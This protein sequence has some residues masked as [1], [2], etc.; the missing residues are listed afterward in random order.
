MNIHFFVPHIHFLHEHLLISI[1]VVQRSICPIYVTLGNLVLDTM[2]T[3]VGSVVTGFCPDCPYD[4]MALEKMLEEQGEL[5]KGMIGR[6]KHAIGHVKR[7][8]EQTFLGELFE[9]VRDCETS[10]PIELQVGVGEHARRALFMPKIVVCA[11]DNEGGGQ[12]MCIRSTKCNKPC[13][14]CAIGREDICT[15]GKKCVCVKVIYVCAQV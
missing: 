4:K 1:N 2:T 5:G 12:V 11:T 9:S 14:I 15:A 8:Y 3:S 13:R 10:G 6:R 7:Y